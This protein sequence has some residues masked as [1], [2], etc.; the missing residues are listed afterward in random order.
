MAAHDFAHP[1]PHAIAHYRAAQR[2]LDAETE[3]A[4]R[5]FIG[6]EKRGEM[7]VGAALAS[8]VHRVEFALAQQSRFSG[9]A[10]PGL[11]RIHRQRPLLLGGRKAMTPLLAARGQHL[12]AALGLHAHAESVCLGAA[13]FPRL[14]CTLWQS[15]PPYFLR[16]F[17]QRFPVRGKILTTGHKFSRRSFPLS[18]RERFLLEES[19]FRRRRH[20][21]NPAP[22]SE[23]RHK[24][25]PGSVPLPA[26][27]KCHPGFGVRFVQPHCRPRSSIPN[28]LV[29]LA[30]TQRVKKPD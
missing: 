10:Q 25:S 23:T 12:A 5:P 7:R 26:H 29:Y 17:L 14:I 22:T 15:N 2:F 16:S 1:P 28:N 18:F 27:S 8:A 19:A 6:A 30:Q 4:Q 11:R 21:A 13:S 3:A 9:K 20:N 24:P